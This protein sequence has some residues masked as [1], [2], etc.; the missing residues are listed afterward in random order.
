ME[1]TPSGDWD[2]DGSKA[3]EEKRRKEMENIKFVGQLGK[4]WQKSHLKRTRALEDELNNENPQASRE[5]KMLMNLI[6]GDYAMC[7]VLLEIELG[8]AKR[9]CTLV[10]NPSTVLALA[11]ALRETTACRGAT[12]GRLQELMKTR[13]VLNGQRKLAQVVPLR[14][15][16]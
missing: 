9:A 8:L 4:R 12:E 13:A 7:E 6:S 16:A 15:V 10:D 2:W 11:R 14:R 3:M 5:E 1:S